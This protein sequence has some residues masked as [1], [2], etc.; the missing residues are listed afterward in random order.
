[1]NTYKLREKQIESQ[2]EDNKLKIKKN[3]NIKIAFAPKY[4]TIKPPQK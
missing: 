3:K 1:M 4:N 2:R